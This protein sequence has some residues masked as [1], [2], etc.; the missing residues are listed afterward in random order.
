M[1]SKIGRAEALLL[2]A[3]I[4]ISGDKFQE[5]IT[6]FEELNQPMETAKAWYYYGQVMFDKALLNKARD[7]FEKIGAKGWLAKIDLWMNECK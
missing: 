1:N 3:R 2:Q 6:V 4:E 7:I 5:A